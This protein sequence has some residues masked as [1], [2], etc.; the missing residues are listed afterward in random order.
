MPTVFHEDVPDG[1]G[2]SDGFGP[3]VQVHHVGAEQVH[4]VLALAEQPLRA[5][6]LRGKRGLVVQVT[7]AICLGKRLAVLRWS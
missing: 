4:V 7:G 5:S 1:V 2:V 6:L 3:L